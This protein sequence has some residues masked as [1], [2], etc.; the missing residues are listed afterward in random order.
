MSNLD[1]LKTKLD[2]KSKA[3][4]RTTL[5][6]GLP[7]I[8]EDTSQIIESQKD[9]ETEVEKT[10]EPAPRKKQKKEPL[11]RKTYYVTKEIEECLRL[12]NFYYRKD[13]SS[14]VR[15]F[16]LQGIPDE[17]LKEAKENIKNNK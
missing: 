12:M 1:K 8:E 5:F 10:E 4:P 15:E 17:I 3:D 11:L 2:E 6:V 16:I 14:L 13:I 9:V 7:K